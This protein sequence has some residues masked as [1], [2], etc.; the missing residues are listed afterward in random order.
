MIYE[1]VEN[2]RA[3]YSYVSELIKP[4]WHHISSDNPFLTLVDQII[5]HLDSSTEAKI[6][7]A[8]ENPEFSLKATTSQ[9]VDNLLT[10]KFYQGLFLGM[11]VRAFEYEHSRLLAET[12]TDVEELKQSIELGLKR[13]DELCGELEESLN[14]KVIPIQKLVKI[15]VEGGLRI[16]NHLREKATC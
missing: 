9:V 2:T 5:T 12:G 15:Q 3:H 14:Y 8:N 13:L 16:V 7:W 11:T 1:N 10:A 4:V 6:N